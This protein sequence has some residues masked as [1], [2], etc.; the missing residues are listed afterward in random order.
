MPKTVETRIS[1]KICFCGVRNSGRK[2]FVTKSFWP[3]PFSRIYEGILNDNGQKLFVL[4]IF[5]PEFF[6][7]K[8]NLEKN[9]KYYF[10]FCIKLLDLT[11]KY[12]STRASVRRDAKGARNPLDLSR[13]R[14]KFSNF[15]PW[16]LT[17]GKPQILSA[18]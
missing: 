7:P 18:I 6:T 16:V 12:L 3:P 5:R 13:I 15:N 17:I 1:G 9:K 4:N 2:M 11:K 14:G 10:F 8:C